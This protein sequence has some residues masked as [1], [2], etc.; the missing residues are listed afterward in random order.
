MV[1]EYGWVVGISKIKLIGYFGDGDEYGIPYISEKSIYFVSSIVLSAD[2]D[3]F[4][5]GLIIVSYG[6]GRYL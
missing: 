2:G 5:F 6:W 3:I 4:C 1:A